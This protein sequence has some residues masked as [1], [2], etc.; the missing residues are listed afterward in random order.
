VYASWPNGIQEACAQF[1]AINRRLPIYIM[2]SRRGSLK[3]Q[4]A[5]KP[6]TVS[7]A[8]VHRAMKASDHAQFMRKTLTEGP[9]SAATA[10]SAAT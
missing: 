7:E 8:C 10:S 2:Y 3:M 6:L 4:L 9:K 1:L 5:G